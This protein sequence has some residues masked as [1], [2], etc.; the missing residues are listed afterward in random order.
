MLQAQE[1]DEVVNTARALDMQEVRRK[2]VNVSPVTIG[3][4]NPSATDVHGHPGVQVGSA[5][6]ALEPRK[7]QPRTAAIQP[8]DSLGV[9]ELTDRNFTPYVSG[10]P[11]AVVNFW[12][13]SSSPSAAFASAFAAAAT[14]NPELLFVKINAEEQRATAAQFKI[15]SIPA[16]LIIRDNIVVHAK[17]GALDA[18]ALREALVAAR[19]LDMEHVRRKVGMGAV[20][21]RGPAV[22]AI[23]IDARAA[24]EAS[25]LSIETYL[26]ASLRGP[27]SALKD[28]GRRLAA[29]ALVT[30]RDAFEP[31]FAERMYR[32][33]DSCNTWRAHENYAERFSYYHHNVYHPEDFPPDV[34]WCWKVFDS[35]GSKAW[36][37]RLSGR[38]CLGPTSVSASWYLP[39]DHSLPHTDNV[40]TGD[41][42]IRQLAFVWHLA[43]EWRSEWGGAF[44][45]CPKACYM[46]PAFNTLYLFNVSSESSHFVTQVS[47]FAVGKRLTINGWWTGPA[48]TPGPVWKGPDRIGTDGTE[49][50]I[51]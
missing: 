9:V 49:I 42:Y 19:A 39:G 24:A 21:P 45:W 38:T 50:L 7:D 17:A 26:R 20:A 36:A 5:S 43:K 44:Y 11:F 29:G 34:A 2:V 16:L 13:P 4:P 18:S 3:D 23:N 30:I 12:A 6:T 41:H 22:P 27:G 35:S 31:D 28:V 14:S 37:T 10:H 40:T 46:P 51:Y 33:L 15:S 32:S 48:A 25:Q 47:P 1:L 8:A